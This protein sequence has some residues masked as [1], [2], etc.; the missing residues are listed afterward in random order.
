MNSEDE[1][2]INNSSPKDE[3]KVEDQSKELLDL[4]NND[5]DSDSD[6]DLIIFFTH[7]RAHV[8]SK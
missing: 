8:N 2:K 1:S 6:N 5:P 7:H 3:Q 4:K